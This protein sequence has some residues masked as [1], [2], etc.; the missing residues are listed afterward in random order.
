MK[1][2]LATEADMAALLGVT[3]TRIRDLAREGIMVKPQRGRYDVA[4]SVKN[5]ASR[6]REQAARA[7]R[8][9]ADASPEAR[10]AKERLT[11]AQARLAESKADQAAGKLLD[12]AEVERAWAGIL[13]D[14]RAGLLAIP[15]RVGASLP[16]LTAHDVATL[17]REL[18]AAM[19]ALSDGR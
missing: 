17:D 12:A 13:R 15:S 10:S 1:F 18:R 3:T 14:L 2:D 9:P 5:Y 11:E 6:L 7:G 19:E 8:P 16:H 4:A